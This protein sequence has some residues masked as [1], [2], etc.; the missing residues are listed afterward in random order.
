MLVFVTG[1]AGSGKSTLCAE[2]S[3]RGHAVH[4]ADDGISRHVSIVSGAEVPTPP[5][6]EQT[7]EWVAR[8]EFRF[9]LERVARLADSASAARPA[10]LLGAAYGDDAVIELADQAWFLHL[11]EPELR[12]RIASRPPDAYGH[13]PHELDAIIAWHG[14]A[15][16]RYEALGA[17]RIEASRPV[18][19]VAD[20]LLAAVLTENPPGQRNLP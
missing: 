18:G 12:R 7:P 5:R 19:E 9:D 8:H 6:A 16:A 15:V 11:G 3:S 2:L 20:E 10:F 17:R 14:A 4:D 13:A 1:V